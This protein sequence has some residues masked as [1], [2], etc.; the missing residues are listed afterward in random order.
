M[1]RAIAFQEKECDRHQLTVEQG[2]NMSR[3]IISAV[4]VFFI[5][6]VAG[7]LVLLLV[8]NPVLRGAIAVSVTAG[9]M[10]YFFNSTFLS[11]WAVGGVMKGSVGGVINKRAN[12]NSVLVVLTEQPSEHLEDNEARAGD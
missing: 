4:A 3:A 7:N 2:T 1:V 11:G 5:I 6:L 10:V 9:L 8:E 12:R